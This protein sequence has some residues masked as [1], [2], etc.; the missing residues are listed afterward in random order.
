MIY[1]LQK[2]QYDAYKRQ[3]KHSSQSLGFLIFK[4]EDG[5][6]YRTDGTGMPAVKE[7]ATF[8]K[9]FKAGID[10]QTSLI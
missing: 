8:N 9:N 1:Q 4:G 7:M 2:K 5:N 3:R 10:N 6:Y